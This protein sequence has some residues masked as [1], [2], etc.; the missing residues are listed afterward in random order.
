MKDITA[1]LVHY[2]NPAALRKA[3]V[4]LKQ[5]NSRLHSI[6]LLH[7]QDMSLSII[8]D[9]I[10]FKKIQCMALKEND[11]GKTLNDTIH[12]VNSSY[13][14]FLQETD[15]LS[16]ALQTESLHLSQSEPFINTLYRNQNIAVHRP[17]LVSTSFLKKQKFLSAFQLP[18]KEAF[19]PAW[20]S[21][22]PNSKKLCRENLV[23]QSRKNRSANTLEKQKF[24]QKYRLNKI[25]TAHPSLSILIS[26]YNMEQYAETAVASCLFQNE[27]PEQVLIMDDGSTD[28]SYNKLKQWE[29]G[30]RISVFE[31]K[32]EGKAIAFNHLLPHV[33][34][35][36]ILELDAD[37]WLD[38][39]AITVIKRLLASLPEDVSVLY[40]NLRKWKQLAGDVL[41][42]G[43]S[44]G[45]MINGRGD[46]LSYRFPLGPR[47]YRASALKSVGG[48]PVIAFEDGMLYE[49]VSVLNQ[50]IQNNRFQYH[51]FTVYNVREHNESITKTNRP[52]WNEFLKSL[53]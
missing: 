53:K 17:F 21:N 43:I 16:P 12:M 11:L 34:S 27:M 28:N 2:S 4:S 5:I 23:M 37:D 30:K 36:F 39:D 47:I 40:G 42:K 6:I 9:D 19:F 18:F 10:N 46:L 48:F 38:P 44:K 13:V 35:D 25:Q 14:L 32:N 33:T 52:D 7:E 8:Q 20:L 45:N 51:D 41:F 15:Y 1:I 3:L 31:K 26:N 49:D 22:K 29:D 50:L 24:M